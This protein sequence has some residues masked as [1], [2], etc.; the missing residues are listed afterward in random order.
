MAT[1]NTA[2]DGLPASSK[3]LH[4]FRDES[5]GKQRPVLADI[6]KYLVPWWASKWKQLGA[7]LNIGENKM[8][9][10]EYNNPHDCERCC[11]KM[12]N[13]WLNDTLDATWD[14]LTIAVD[15]LPSLDVTVQEAFSVLR[16]RYVTGRFYMSGNHWPP[17]QPKHYTTLALIHYK[18]AYADTKVISI[19]KLAIKGKAIPGECDSS[20]TEFDGIGT[21][22][23]GDIFKNI[24]ELF[25]LPSTADKSTFD[26]GFILIEGVPGIGKTILS[27]EI[28]YQ[29]ANRNL[30]ENKKLLFLV[31]LRNIRSTTVKSIEEFVKHILK[32]GEMAPSIRKYLR[33]SKGKD[34]VVVLDG[35]DELSEEDKKDSYIADIISRQVLSHCL[36]VVTSR[37]IASL[38]LRHIA[39][40]RLEIVGFTEED[41]LDYIKSALSNSRDRVEDLQDYL[42]SN[43]TINALCYIPLN[44]T[45]LLCLC[46]KGIGNLP[47][48]QTEMY[49]KFIVMTITRFLQKVD[50][51]V[52]DIGIVNLNNLPHPHNEIL[53][54]LSRFAFEALKCDKLVF[55]LDEI[56][57]ICP[58]L[59]TIPS[60]W[61]GLGLLNS[62]TYVEDGIKYVTYHFLHF[63]IQEYM[64]AYY[65]STLSK[66]MQIKLLKRTFWL[67]NYYN[68]WIMY[69]GITGGESF[70]L[71]HFLSENLLQ[72]T[73]K[74]FNTGISKKLLNSKIK[75]LHMF[76]C[77]AEAQ[78]DDL[79]SSVSFF[80]KNQVID[81]SEQTLLPKDLSTLGFFLI[82]SLNKHWK[83]LNLSRCSIGNIGCKVLF[84]RFLDKDTR[85][86]VTIDRVDLSFNQLSSS[87]WF[88]LFNMLKSWQTSEVVI[89]DNTPLS[90]DTSRNL[91]ALIEHVFIQSSNKVCLK[92]IFM[93]SFLF[94]YKL[95]EEE[96]IGLLCNIRGIESIYFINCSCMELNDFLMKNMLNRQKLNHVHLLGEPLNSTF[97]EAV[98]NAV[99]FYRRNTSWVVYAPSLS[100]SFAHQMISSLPDVFSN[101]I[102]VV[103][104][105]NK[106]QGVINT[107]SLSSELS[108]LEILNL[109]AKIRSLCSIHCPSVTSW[110]EN[111]Q[112][113]GNKSEGII[114]SFLQLLFSLKNTSVFDIKISLIEANTLFAHR[115]NY[116][117]ISRALICNHSLSAIYL[118]SCNLSMT[119]YEE[120]IH[121]TKNS[122]L[123]LCILGCHLK[124]ASLFTVLS[125]KKCTIRELFLHSMR[126]VTINDLNIMLS[127]CQASSVV[128]VTKDVLVAHNPLSKQLSAA[129][130]LEPSVKV[131]KFLS[132]QLNPETCKQIAALLSSIN[133]LD[134]LEFTGCHIGKIECE[135]LCNYILTTRSA[136]IIWRLLISSCKIAASVSFS[137]TKVVIVSHVEE[138]IIDY[139]N[140]IPYETLSEHLRSNLLLCQQR[141]S[142]LVSCNGVRSRF[143]TNVEWKRIAE[144]LATADSFTRLYLIN[145]Q[146]SCLRH[147]KVAF[148]LDKLTNLSHV[149]ILNGTLLETA[150]VSIFNV[151]KNRRLELYICDTIAINGKA[152]FDALT[153]KSFFYELQAKISLAVTMENFMCCYNISQRQFSLLSKNANSSVEHSIIALLHKMECTNKLLVFQN[154]QLTA[155]YFAEDNYKIIGVTQLL[156][157]LS[158]VVSLKHFGIENIVI[159]KNDACT[160]TGILNQNTKIEKL[161][162]N[163]CF[164][165]TDCFNIV[166]KALHDIS[167]LKVLGFYDNNITEEGVDLIV[168][169]V[170]DNKQ[171]SDLGFGNSSLQ[172]TSIIKLSRAMMSISTILQLGLECNSISEKAADHIAD[173]LAHNTKL[174]MLRLD[175][176]ILQTT[177]IIQISKALQKITT[178]SELYIGNNNITEEAADYVAAIVSNNS[179]L[180]ILNLNGNK[181]QTVGIK[182][183]AKALQNL[184]LLVELYIS[185][186][187]ITKEAANDIAEVIMN[188]R[189]IQKLSL[190]NNNFQSV[191]IITVAKALKNITSLT[192]LYIDNNNVTLEAAYDTAEV[193]LYNRKIQTFG[194]SNNNFQTVGVMTVSKALKRISSL[195]KLYIDNNNVTVEAA[196]DIAEVIMNNCNLQVLSLSNNILKATGIIKVARALRNIFSLTEL[197]IGSNKINENAIDD[198]A[199]VISNNTMLQKLDL[200]NNSFQ[201]VGIIKIMKA[202]KNIFI[203]NKSYNDATEGT[204]VDDVTMVFPRNDKF[205]VLNLSNCNLQSG[206]I[207]IVANCLQSI[208]TLTELYLSNNCITEEAASAIANTILNNAK[209]KKVDLGDNH[210]QTQGIISIAKALQRLSSLTELYL[211]NNNITEEAADDIA[212]VILNNNKLQKL[213]LSDNKFQ[214]IGTIKVARVLKYVTSLTKLHIKNNDIADEAADDIAAV[215]LNNRKLQK[216]CL[217]NNNLKTIGIRKI[218]KALLN[219]SSL[220]ELDIGN[221]CINVEAANDIADAVLHNTSLQGLNLNGNFLTSTGV[222]AVA[223]SLQCISTLECLALEGNCS[224]ETAA[225]YIVSV[226]VQNTELHMLN[227]GNNNLQTT[228]II[229]VAKCL[230]NITTLTELYLHSN[231]ITEEAA[232]AIATAIIENKKLQK[233]DLGKNNFQSS[234]MLVIAKALQNI[235]SLTELYI[236]SNNITEKAADD[237][238][239]AILNNCALKKLSIGDNDLQTFG[240]ITIASALLQ[241][242]FSLT[243]LYLHKNSITE[244]AADFVANVIQNS[245]DLK[246]LNIGDNDFQ[247]LGTIKIAMALQKQNSLIELY[248][249]NNKI[250]EEAADGVA[251][252]ILNNHKLQVLSLSDNHFQT[253]GII[254]IARALKNVSSLTKLYINNNNISEEGAGD[255]AVVILK[256]RQLKKLHLSNNNL[257][258]IGIRKIAK[259]LLNISSLVELDIGNNCINVEAANDIADA[260]LHNTSLQG[261][262]LNGNFLTCTG[263]IAVAKSLQCISTLE[264][265]ALEGNCSID[266][267]ETVADCIESVLLQNTEL[268]VLN[269][270]N[271]NLQTTGIIKVTKCLQNITTL[272][273]LYLHSNNITEEAADYVAVVI[274]NNR[275]LKALNIGDNHFQ[276]LGMIKIA[277]ALQKVF[278]LT[279][280]YLHNN[281]ITKEAADYVAFVILNNNKLQKLSLSDN[282]FETIGIIKIARALQNISSLTKLYINNTNISDKAADDIAAV[283]AHNAKL[284][285]LDLSYNHLHTVGIEKIA[286]ALDTLTELNIRFNNVNQYEEHRIEAILQLELMNINS[287]DYV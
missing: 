134:E 168:P 8:D 169:V 251:S 188:N 235:T 118:A 255:I 1:F 83:E 154:C 109:I 248:L 4:M 167:S 252:V 220:V 121:Y 153:D 253:I 193:I 175:D 221:N 68:T 254:K 263:V 41:R 115:V 239:E 285:V 128:L 79:I 155:V 117:G 99:S 28:A 89:F 271:N 95:S 165:D 15:K 22:S 63:S 122:L 50:K 88:G 194:L 261:L 104:S 229:K 25:A 75:C 91:F 52:S 40:C 230:Q 136:P 282:N 17:Y 129:I 173:V 217:S 181:F 225:N 208:T 214:T 223:K 226:L 272:T 24:S 60:N 58:S 138:L 87:S 145:C 164:Q 269:L 280:L 127:T 137:L 281:N 157:L 62:V 218:A 172:D 274:Q 39:D 219:I 143:F 64:A 44:M 59:T 224:T 279:E 94:G 77:L 10:I 100:D 180:K 133:R 244:E 35:Y 148:G 195:S 245:Y 205:R 45:I 190:S 250:A 126:Y 26:S 31:F 211:H 191:G 3:F 54:E 135:I 146:L 84:E 203:P 183:I 209:L 90:D 206:G 159:R 273:K 5:Q 69:V 234:G 65:M 116:D 97:V 232:V 19:K 283:V 102:V 66:N 38:P 222:I 177:G 160:L 240:T 247:T 260:V 140:Y 258:T 93:G 106:I 161:F 152:L 78:N 27:K 270:G 227:L 189:N 171:L 202:L 174:Q 147:S 111:L 278:S 70:P 192:A 72:I 276:A 61:N 265:L 7:Q 11:S 176:N 34:L 132:C 56:Q 103:V 144:K 150:I 228:G 204:A 6:N 47:K 182:K 237:I 286:K 73:T 268:H 231:N 30:L 51:N 21:R 210:F 124:L 241:K 33:E 36:L 158:S 257:K 101:G 277:K 85:P 275:N 29:W 166:I 215:I 96:T 212:T 55:K 74:L 233:L 86:I 267:T 18:E 246:R 207:I 42:K 139:N 262:N 37:P 170:A 120:I 43:P 48:T 80:F 266:F 14:H 142:L 49:K 151:F 184:Y 264:C 187:N 243:E 236:Y 23:G 57:E 13:D 67:V 119:E 113:H 71:Q 216:L 105:Y 200:S 82:R 199:A 179:A 196:D 92:S 123:F 156:S 178:L 185:N 98:G 110:N 213:S 9:I 284:Q 107:S 131:C 197:Y 259:A 16:D 238:A 20:P 108:D 125:K 53:Q 163:N 198:I 12:L 32:S 2:D 46:K 256:N 201:R 76:Q 141:I 162:L 242:N 81:L 130:K 114:E 186:N 249:H 149:Y 287:I 112:W